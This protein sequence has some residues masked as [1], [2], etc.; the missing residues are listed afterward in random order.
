MGEVA[1]A[2]VQRENSE[3]GRSLKGH[4]ISEH[5]KAVLSHQSS[6]D[7]VWWLGEDGVHHEYPKTAS[8]KIVSFLSFSLFGRGRGADG[9]DCRGRSS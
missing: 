4:H 1:G 2:F 7:W 9:F 6:P 3:L 5:I 8:G